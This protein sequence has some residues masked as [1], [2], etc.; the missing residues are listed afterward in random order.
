MKRNTFKFALICAIIV[1]AVNASVPLAYAAGVCEGLSSAT[2][3]FISC[4]DEEVSFTQPGGEFAPPSAELYTEGLTRAG[5][6]QEFAVNV[7][8]FILGFLG[9][10]GVI[11]IIYGGFLYVT[12]GV[13]E[14]QAGKGK[15]TVTY[16]VIGILLVMVSFAL[17]NTLIQ[18]PSGEQPSDEI[19]GAGGTGAEAEAAESNARRR[20]AYASGAAVVRAI[21]Q[22]VVRDYTLYLE[23]NEEINR[24]ENFVDALTEP[25]E[26]RRE[27][28][29]MGT[30]LQS[31]VQRVDALSKTAEKARSL[32]SYVHFVTTA[33]SGP[34]FEE[35]VDNSEVMSLDDGVNG[36]KQ[37]FREGGGVTRARPDP[38]SYSY[39]FGIGGSTEEEGAAGTEDI[40]Q[41]TIADFDAQLAKNIDMLEEVRQRHFVSVETQGIDPA[42]TLR[43]P[44]ERGKFAQAEKALLEMIETEV[45]FEFFT[46]DTTR[47]P[48]S[49]LGKSSDGIKKTIEELADLHEAMKDM[50]F[51]E[52]KI[53]ASAVEGNAPLI[54]SLEG[55]R[56][57]D[58]SERS[59]VE[60]L[61]GN[62]AEIYQWDLLGTCPHVTGAATEGIVSASAGDC[63]QPQDERFKQFATCKI[64]GAIANC[65]YK[66]PGK[67]RVGLRIP[68]AE[69]DKYAWGEVFIS[70]TVHAPRSSIFLRAI[71]GGQAFVLND[72]ELNIERD[73]LAITAREARAGGVIFSA[74]GTRGRGNA[75]IAK[76]IWDFGG[77]EKTS[78]T[79]SQ[80]DPVSFSRAGRYRIVLE[81]ADTT[82]NRDR[83]LFDVIVGDVAP[84]IEVNR[85]SGG[86]STPFSFDGTASRS[87]LGQI[88]SYQWTL[89]RV[90]E[91]PEIIGDTAQ[92]PNYVFSRPGTYTLRLTVQDAR[93]NSGSIE[94]TITIASQAPQAR[95]T[96]RIPSQTKPGTVHLNAEKTYDPDPG[97]IE[98]IT[99]QNLLK[100]EVEEKE[101]GVDYEMVDTE[102]PLHSILKFISSASV[103]DNIV[104]LTVTDPHDSSKQST[105][106]EVVTV[107]SIL[108]VD[109]AINP[110]VKKLENGEATI[111]FAPQSERAQSAM[112]SFGDEGTG[113]EEEVGEVKSIT[114]TY[115]RAGVYDV[116]LR[117]E[118]AEGNKN[119]LMKRV[120]ISGGDKPLAVSRIFIDDE[121]VFDFSEPIIVNRKKRVRFDASDSVDN[122]GRPQGLQYSWDFGDGTKS[123]KKIVTKMFEEVTPEDTPYI[124]NLRVVLENDPLRFADIDDL[125]RPEIIVVNEPPTASALLA[126]PD[127]GPDGLV[128]PLP[129]RLVLVRPIDP[130]GSIVQYR[131]WYYEDGFDKSPEEGL[132]LQISRTPETT[133]TISTLGM[134]DEEHTYTFGV[135]LMDNEGR[136]SGTAEEPESRDYLDISIPKIKVKNGVNLS[137]TVEVNVDKTNVILG[138]SVTFLAEAED[139][140]GRIV[141]YLWD[142]EGDGFFN[143]DPADN[144]ANVV[145]AFTQRA[146]RGIPVR[147][148][149]VDN[150]GNSTVSNPVRIFITGLSNPS[151]A[152]FLYERTE[153][154]TVKFTN[155]SKVDTEAG[156]SIASYGWDFDTTK[157]SDGNGKLD[158]DL[159]S[160]VASPEHEYETPGTYRVKLTIVDSEGAQDDVIN[161]VRIEPVFLQRATNLE[162]RLLTDPEPNAADGKVHFSGDEGEATFDF[163]GSL[164]QIIRYV[165]DKNIFFDSNGNNRKDDDE[166]Y[167]T[168]RTGTWTTNFERAW[169]RI[170]VKLTVYDNTGASSSVTREIMFDREQGTTPGAPPGAVQLNVAGVPID[171]GILVAVISASV[172]LVTGGVYLR[173]RL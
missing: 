125:V 21:G 59:I 145:H 167:S 157:D 84:R 9:L 102:D 90:G 131:F 173:R 88:E 159:D 23:V 136:V 7:T 93:Q 142:F 27:L 168:D 117:I 106:K 170:M 124:V 101:E 108:D 48:S 155:T 42:G 163:R 20:A 148:K 33:M 11:A 156:I 171:A 8:N 75:E 70:L 29:R 107:S 153:G 39:H 71:L 120:F 111:T 5:N 112:W 65:A 2:R 137:P 118:D 161:T 16:A 28:G 126:L 12:A 46:G 26:I 53:S 138:E 36:F 129:V 18:A 115:T 13:S 67:Y 165:I 31:I 113:D 66:V 37:A 158:D 123:T 83:K 103:G 82:G 97:D 77:G 15:K 79:T 57:Y 4:G 160:R 40:R 30:T 49:T 45:E 100:W 64:E 150:G 104:N 95:F 72:P 130:D 144:R 92:V 135:E 162:A 62:E 89:Q 121:E 86:L 133:L 169:G 58:P 149:V 25:E 74:E 34:E 98:L 134:T 80:V 41:A 3:G 99:E 166:D 152:A 127:P 6:V 38:G 43:A 91:K 147:L 116:V 35:L 61:R 44:G 10:V 143:S 47:M 94:Q 154:T 69:P 172:I 96:A 105:F 128:T 151:E 14:D 52:T 24:L 32:L 87:D 140:D 119:E 164:G 56:S 63:L 114:H 132:G 51:V 55:V 17:V 110:S 60:G 19:G 22:N 122:Q 81:V 68:P 146:P 85:T 76:Y 1:S 109:F 78:V 54:V 141:E 73:S 139:P 50:K